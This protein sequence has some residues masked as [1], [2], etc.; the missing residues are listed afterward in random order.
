MQLTWEFREDP[1]EAIA[2]FAA[3]PVVRKLVDRLLKYSDET[4]A[5]LKGVAGQDVMLILGQELPWVDGVCYL[6]RDP[7]APTLLLP[8]HSAPKPSAELLEQALDTRDASVPVAVIPKGQLLV[9]AGDALPLDREDLQT[10]L[11]G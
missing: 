7:M 4:L 10:Y 8:T 9:P 2:L 1:L 11:A 5:A 6:G 3:G